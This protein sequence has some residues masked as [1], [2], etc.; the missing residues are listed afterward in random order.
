MSK[1]NML[2]IENK[3]DKSSIEQ[4]ITSEKI[5]SSIFFV[6]FVNVLKWRSEE[7][8]LQQTRL[9]SKLQ[10]LVRDKMT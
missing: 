8:M 5:K 6:V 1:K 7:Q 2:N 3:T 9:E 4:F 10:F